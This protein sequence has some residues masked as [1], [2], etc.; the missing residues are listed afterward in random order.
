MA[1][2]VLEE[3]ELQK[4]ITDAVKLAAAELRDEL[5]RSRTPELMDKGLLTKYLRCHISSIN[6]F[7]K[8]GM[9]FEML[10]EHPRFR[11]SD[12]D[13]WLKGGPTENRNGGIQTLQRS[14]N[15]DEGS[16]LSKGSVVGAQ[17]HPRPD[18]PSVDP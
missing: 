12:I 3:S 11:K 9:P 6:R 10:G 5:E 17:V 16:E 14:A 15:N 7:M 1:I 18:H 2:A 8:N 4:I 13:A